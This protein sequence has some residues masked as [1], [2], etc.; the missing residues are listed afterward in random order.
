MNAIDDEKPKMMGTMYIIV[1]VIKRI[2]FIVKT[3]VL[4]IIVILSKGLVY[5]LIYAHI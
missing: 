5:V 1:I 4:L 2:V 3:L